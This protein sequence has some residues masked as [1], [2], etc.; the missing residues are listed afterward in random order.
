METFSGFL[1]YSLALFYILEA[2]FGGS[3]AVA[4][5]ISS[6]V[7]V[8]FYIRAKQDR[9]FTESISKTTSIL[10]QCEP[11]NQRVKSMFPVENFLTSSVLLGISSN[12]IVPV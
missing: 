8:A 7:V 3:L 9:V 10:L 11:L 5:F 1:F 12:F 2:T 6:I 4:N